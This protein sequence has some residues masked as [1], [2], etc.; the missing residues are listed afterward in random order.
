MLRTGP[1][2]RI[3]IHVNDDVSSRKNF[4]HEEILQLLFDR[5]MAGATLLRVQ[6]GFGTH[7]RVHTAGTLG[8]AGEH[9]PVR[10]EFVE[11]R[12][13]VETLLPALYELIT[14]GMIEAQDTTILK[15]AIGS[16]ENP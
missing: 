11:T 14:D 15:A 3:I 10:I 4:L 9:L 7:H 13:A 16:N 6:A 8:V 1:A 2:L 12:A 5:G